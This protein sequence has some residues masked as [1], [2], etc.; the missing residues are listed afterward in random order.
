MAIGGLVMLILSGKYLVT[1]GV[2]LSNFFNLSPLI[3]GLTV[4][5]FGTS[6]P[7]LIVSLQAVLQ[8]HPDIAVGNVIGSNIANI[9]LVLALT[10]M[11][12]PIKVKSK[13]LLRDWSVMFGASLLL[14]FFIQDDVLNNWEALLLFILLIAYIVYSV[15]KTGGNV[16][17]SES[18]GKQLHISLIL[19]IIILS[20]AGLAFGSDLLVKGASQIARNL[21]VSDKIISISLI[22]FGTSVPELATS[23]IAAIR[24]EMDISI[25]NIIGSNIFNVLAVLGISG[26]VKAIS[27]PKFHSIYLFDFIVMLGVSAGL[28]LLLL[29]LRKGLL[30]RW[31]GAL[32]FMIYG[33]YIYLLV[34]GYTPF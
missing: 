26:T 22:A 4:I 8:D 9:A 14:F 12:L 17:K 3:I 7:E 20:S 33:L 25:G 15:K 27:I 6:A 16:E 31:K 23:I 19:L 30:T 29:P 18:S 28:L 10:A 32:M 24:K 2:Q 13:T 34:I 1:G 11:I 21:G 5:A